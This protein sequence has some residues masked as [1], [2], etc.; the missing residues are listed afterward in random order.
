MQE[1]EG[2]ILTTGSNDSNWKKWIQGLC[3]SVRIVCKVAISVF[4]GEPEGFPGK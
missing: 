4:E 1:K 2:I 3:S